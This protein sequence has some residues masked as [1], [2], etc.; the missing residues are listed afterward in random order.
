MYSGKDKKVLYPLIGDAARDQFGCSIAGAGDV[1]K[2]GHGD[3]IV[4]ARYDDNNGTDAGSAR[5]F[6]TAR[7]GPRLCCNGAT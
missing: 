6:T 1:D 7:P 3:F 2:D 5:V 4:G